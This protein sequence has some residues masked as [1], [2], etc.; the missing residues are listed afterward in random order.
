MRCASTVVYSKC[1]CF[2]HFLLV[3][4]Y[5]FIFRIAL[6]SSAGKELTSWLSA[7]AV[8]LNAVLIVYVLFPFGVWDRMWNSIVS[9]PDNCLFI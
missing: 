5:L 3:C 8:L 7:Y 2:F 6:W 4:D 1:H 9:V